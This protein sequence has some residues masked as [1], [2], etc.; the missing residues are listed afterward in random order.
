[1]ISAIPTVLNVIVATIVGL[2]FAMLA[3][4]RHYP[5]AGV[6]AVF[7]IAWVAAFAFLVATGATEAFQ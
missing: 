2:Y 1:M 5:A 6:I 7:I 4:W 3:A